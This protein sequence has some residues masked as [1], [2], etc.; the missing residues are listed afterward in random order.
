MVEDISLTNMKNIANFGKSKKSV[1]LYIYIRNVFSR[2]CTSGMRH[3]WFSWVNSWWKTSMIFFLIFRQNF[4]PFGDNLWFI[5]IFVH[6]SV[7]RK[8]QHPKTDTA[9]CITGTYNWNR[10]GLGKG[11]TLRLT[12]IHISWLTVHGK[13]LRK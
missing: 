13:L 1:W 7:D 5:L 2:P 10:Q 11:H 12:R 6:Y 4:M 3:T 8:F 9:R